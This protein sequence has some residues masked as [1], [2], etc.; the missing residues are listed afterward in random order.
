MQTSA[1]S[2]TRSLELPAAL[3]YRLAGAAAFLYTTPEELAASLLS[4][5]LFQMED[6][7]RIGRPAWRKPS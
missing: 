4:D 5:S 3:R 6:E 7:E 2:V 1:P